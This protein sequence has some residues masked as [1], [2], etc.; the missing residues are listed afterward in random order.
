MK[1][2]RIICLNLFFLILIVHASARTC[3]ER[4]E[5]LENAFQ[6]LIENQMNVVTENVD[7]DPKVKG[8]DRCPNLEKESKL[9]KRKLEDLE[10]SL[11]ESNRRIIELETRVSELEFSTQ[12]MESRWSTE[13]SRKKNLKENI[14]SNTD[15]VEYL[16]TQNTK[17]V[18]QRGPAQNKTS[19][20]K[21]IGNIADGNLMISGEKQS[22]QRGK[23]LLTGI[24]ST[25]TPSTGGAAFSAYV[26]VH[27]TDISKDHTIKFDTIVT[28]IGS[29]YNQHSGVFTAPE[30]GV[31]VFSW[32]LYC[33]SGGYIF[34]QLVVNSNVVGA[35]FTSGEGDN[36][37]RTTTEIVVV[38]VN[39]GDVVYVRTHPTQNHLN[40]LYSHP[41]W[42]SS[43]SGWKVY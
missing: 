36:A 37:L 19:I 4:L 29:H 15:R 40:N 5:S 13:N 32:N 10:K 22:T 42:R 34:S 8:S 1:V 17:Q 25:I 26:S 23:R 24:Q 30:Q 14:K 33:H 20:K 41:D 35:M 27:E 2:C 43:F 31:Y 16:Q 9:W 39:A 21:R 38:Q 12:Y 6:S 3:E 11:T 28:N 18:M 7:P